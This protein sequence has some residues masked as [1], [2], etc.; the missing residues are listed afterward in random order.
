MSITTDRSLLRAALLLL[1]V[2]NNTAPAAW[3]TGW[4][5]RKQI[6]VQADQVDS[7]LSNFPLCVKITSDSDLG[8]A[9]NDGDDIR[10]TSSDGTT[11]LYW[12]E[13]TWSGGGGSA[14]TSVHW[15]NIATIDA[16]TGATIYVY[17][18]KADA[19]DASDTDNTWPAA[20]KGV[21]HMNV[22]NGTENDSSGN[23][24][25]L[26]EYGG[27]MPTATGKIGTARDFESGDTENLQL[28]DEGGSLD[29]NGANQAISL[30]AWIRMESNTAATQHIVGKW[31]SSG[32]GRQYRLIANATPA[33][34]GHLSSNGTTQS[35]AATGATTLTADGTTWYH[36]VA[37][38]NDTDV[39]V[40]INGALDSNGSSNPAAYVDGI[41]NGAV[42]FSIGACD[43]DSFNFYFDGLID[44][45]RV[46]N[47][48][49]SADWIKFEYNNVNSADNELTW[50]AQETPTAGAQVI[51]SIQE[52][53]E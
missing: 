10:F 26:A 33:A 35:I 20:Y 52:D 13:D 40:Y 49:L 45:V 18:G 15:V 7:N 27:S 28:S 4:S 44:E 3:L 14:V 53:D 42:R 25:N 11:L 48:A 16:D 39:R 9:Q 5:Y 50:G 46:N 29:I 8:S 19:T 37:A 24:K 32:Y 22:N 36:I 30:S 31:V 41:Y 51:V 12:E 2:L 21:W 23:A 38:Y 43:S 6:T 1:L 47:T 17:Y 34:T